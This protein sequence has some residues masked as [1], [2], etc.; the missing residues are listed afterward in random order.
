MA[1]QEL[2]R[3]VRRAAARET[4]VDHMRA[5]IPGQ[6]VFL[7]ASIDDYPNRSYPPPN[8]DLADL[9]LVPGRGTVIDEGWLASPLLMRDFQAGQIKLEF[10]DKLP[11]ASRAEP[12]PETVEGLPQTMK[13]LVRTIAESP[14][15]PQYRQ[16]LSLGDQVLRTGIPKKNSKVTK[17]YL[18][19]EY[20]VFLRAVQIFESERGARPDVLAL[21]AAQL[22]KI[23][24]L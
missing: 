16:I 20:T 9:Y 10:S 24:A 23:E 12:D 21:I 3:K 15:T 6:G 4:V 7:V 14:F 19:G 22:T 8:G 5:G 18:K 1:T 13:L 11:A 17:G 2:D